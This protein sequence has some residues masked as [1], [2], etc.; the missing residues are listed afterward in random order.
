MI[1]I[2]E[3]G[4]MYPR[5]Q[6][7]KKL[8]KKTRTIISSWVG[9]SNKTRNMLLALNASWTVVQMQDWDFRT[10]SCKLRFIVMDNAICSPACV[11]IFTIMFFRPKHRS[12][13]PVCAAILWNQQ[14]GPGR[15]Q[16]GENCWYSKTRSTQKES[17]G[18]IPDDGEPDTRLQ[19]ALHHGCQNWSEVAFFH[20]QLNMKSKD[21]GPRLEPG[22]AGCPGCK[23]RWD[24]ETLWLFRARTCR[25]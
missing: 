22:E 11:I 18:R 4:R 12:V 21:V 19:A 20:L 8:L 2:L 1:G 24:K 6:G 15:W 3:D 7:N 17:T 10:I 5:F 25:L 16:Q 9:R 14:E 13:L 23:L